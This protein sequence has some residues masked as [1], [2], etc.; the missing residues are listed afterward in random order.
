MENQR[1][2]IDVSNM[3]SGQ[4]F[5]QEFLKCGNDV[6][7]LSGENDNLVFKKSFEPE[8]KQMFQ[9]GDEVRMS[10][11]IL[12]FNGVKDNGET[13][14]VTGITRVN[15]QILYYLNNGKYVFFGY[16]LEKA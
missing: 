4:E 16:E 3:R 6:V 12:D 5:V 9:L 14:I 15:E 2:V 1:T 10:K 8:T 7:V 11:A 13:F